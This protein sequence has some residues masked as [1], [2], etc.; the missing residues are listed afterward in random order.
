MSGIIDPC[1]KICQSDSNGLCYGCQRTIE[2]RSNWSVYSDEQRAKILK[3]L[4]SR[5]NTQNPN[6]NLFLR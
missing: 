2:E 4:T 5:S 3:E 1:V 6:Q